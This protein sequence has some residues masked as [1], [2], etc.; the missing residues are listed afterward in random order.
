MSLPLLIIWLALFDPRSDQTGHL[1]LRHLRLTS[2]F[3]D[4]VHPITGRLAFHAGIDLAAHSDTVFA[5]L[6]GVVTKSAY[7][8]RLG[9]YVKIGHYGGLQS[10]YG[11]LSVAWVGITDTLTAGQPIGI[12]GA[13]G[14]VTGEHLHFSIQ[15]QNRYLDP[16]RFLQKLLTVNN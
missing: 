9:I 4:R 3:G 1:P 11:H 15:Y 16:L 2:S 8:E 7:D 13:T 14:R 10:T 5:V 6:G 12:T